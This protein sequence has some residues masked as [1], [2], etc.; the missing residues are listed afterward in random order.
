MAFVHLASA[1]MTQTMNVVVGQVDYAFP[2]AQTGDMT[3]DIANTLTIG[4]RTFD[5]NSIS[6]IFVDD[7]AVDDNTVV[8]KYNGSEASVVV[9]GNIA[10]FVDASVAGADVQIT[11]ADEVE[12]EISYRL[13]GSSADGSFYLS[14]KYKATVIMDNLSLTSLS[15]AAVNIDNGKRIALELVGASSLTDAAEGSQKACFVVKGHPEVTG[16]GSLSLTGLGH[17]THTAI[18]AGLMGELPNTVEP[19]KLPG[20]I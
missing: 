18:L 10:R 15:G 11:Q 16:S 8:V 20:C 4:G 9:A 2:A 1:A 13:T 14:G 17:A 12:E 5:V 3:Y 6:S 19:D 7:A